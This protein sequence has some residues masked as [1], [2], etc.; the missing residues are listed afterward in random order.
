M[1]Q[2]PN[3]P[4]YGD[5]GEE[6]GEGNPDP[7]AQEEGSEDN[8]ETALV[9]KSLLGDPKV[10]DVCKIKV[11]RLHEAEA[12]IEWVKEDKE[13]AADSSAPEDDM[14]MGKLAAM[15]QER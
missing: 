10:G 6:S 11:V 5:T 12:E 8:Q 1:P 4:A 3:Y 7:D 9:P 2:D 15:G 13:S 14:G